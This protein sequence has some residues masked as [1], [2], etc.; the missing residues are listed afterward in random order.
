MCALQIVQKINSE[1]PNLSR[2]G[3]FVKSIQQELGLLRSSTIVHVKRQANLA[4]HELA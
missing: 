4:T 1:S 3:H 2:I